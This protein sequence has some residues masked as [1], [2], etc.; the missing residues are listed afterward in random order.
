MIELSD[1]PEPTHD[2]FE[3]RKAFV[4]VLDQVFTRNPTR[5]NIHK[6]HRRKALASLMGSLVDISESLN[7]GTPRRAAYLACDAEAP[8]DEILGAYALLFT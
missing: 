2:S 5:S 3:A 4:Q 6:H 8:N 1:I 7:D